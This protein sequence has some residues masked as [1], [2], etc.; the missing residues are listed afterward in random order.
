MGN[1]LPAAATIGDP[2]ICRR[3]IEILLFKPVYQGLL[4]VATDIAVFA[5][6]HNL[7]YNPYSNISLCQGL[8]V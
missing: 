7:F 6:V 2:T 1:P 5:C 8:E 4:A 3:E